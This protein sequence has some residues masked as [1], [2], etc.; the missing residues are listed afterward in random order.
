VNRADL[1][2]DAPAKA[3]SG[4]YRGVAS[5][6]LA[7]LNEGDQVAVAVRSSQAG[8]HIPDDPAV[9]VIMVCAGT[10]IAPFRGFIQERAVRKAAGEDVGTALLFFGIRD[11]DVDFLHRAE[12]Q[13]WQDDGVVRLRMDF[14]ARPK[15]GIVHVQNA[16]W[17]HRAEI[18]DLFRAGAHIFVCGDGKRMAPAVRDTL[19]DIYQHALAIDRD[20][21]ER[22]AESIEREAIRYVADVFS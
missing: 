5:S 13:R 19:I 8:F 10:G 20:A 6:F 18:E 22:W 16:I 11:P 12:L 17:H 21:A 4:R 14:S 9:P 15:G 7:R 2:L 1:V 3:G